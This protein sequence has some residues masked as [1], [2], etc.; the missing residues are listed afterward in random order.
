MGMVGNLRNLT[1]LL[2][3]AVEIKLCGPCFTSCVNILKL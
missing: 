2:L 3:E 1:S